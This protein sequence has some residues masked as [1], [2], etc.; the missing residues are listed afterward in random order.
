MINYLL[1]VFLNA[2]TDLG[3]KIIIQNTIFKVYDA[4]EQILLTAIVNSLILLPFI[5]MFSP[6]GFLADRF[7]KNIIMKY[8]SFFAILITLL[9]TYSYYEGCFYTA[10][11][12]TF[13]LAMQSAIYS[14]SKYGYIKELLGESRISYGNASIQAVTTSA[15]LL[16][17]IFYSML[18]EIMIGD[19]FTTQ[20][21]IIKT[22]APLGWLLVLGSIIEAILASKLPN[23]MIQSSSKVFDF[24]KY[25]SGDYLKQNLLHVKGNTEVFNAVISLGLFWSI[26]QVILAIF[27]EYA[28]S[29][30]GI[31][32]VMVVQGLMSL[33]VIGIVLGSIVA[34]KLSRYY[35]KVGLSVFGAICIT[36]IVFL[37]PLTNSVEILGI[38][39]IFFGIF[40]G[41]II[42]PLNSKIQLLSSNHELGTILAGSNYIQTL[43][44]F[45]FLMLT[46]A[47]TYF[48]A[49]ATI[50]F[51]IVGFISIYLS[52]KLF[53]NYFV[54]FCWSIIELVL[55]SRH[56][57]HYIDLENIPKDR[58][59]L[60]VGN[61][62][63]WIDWFI[64]Q[65]PIERRINFMMEKDI[66]KNRFLYPVL[67]KANII[68]I[69]SRASKDA[70]IEASRRLENG[71]IV[72][73]FPEGS[74]SSSN[75]ISK[76]QRGYEYIDTKDTTVVPFYISGAF[77]STFA[78]YKG[79]NK[80]SFIKKREFRVGFGEPIHNNIKADDLKEVICG[81]KNN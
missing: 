70:F 6:S 63:S 23:K 78:R 81:L 41:F 62:V 35:I 53:S 15:I 20:E 61:H 74:I 7:A 69:S 5:L 72:V 75:E 66:Y 34:A 77:G 3:H 65:L 48:G 52:I 8:S 51:Y 50:L 26:S 36:F 22:I 38:E 49:N 59:V 80:K 21:D 33:S 19:I 71:E 45:S 64:L 55:K 31:T 24:K 57:Y 68:P 58:A 37:I 46:T 25:F 11:G 18:F 9:I 27:G 47:F 40:S 17:I 73:I 14:P 1:V 60:L 4:Q 44:M 54:L 43:F 76:F 67:K 79:S 39:F 56:K 30:L 13:L 2:F 42:V 28:K 32:N 29:E 10:F 12:L 16:G